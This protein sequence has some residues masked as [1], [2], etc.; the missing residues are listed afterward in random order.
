MA[1]PRD[2]L[3][4]NPHLDEWCILSAYVGSIAHGTYC[5]TKD[6]YATDDKDVQAFCVPP[7]EYYLGL[8]NFGLG[9]RET[10]EI[11]RGDWD[12]VCHETRK[13]IRLLRQGNP[14]ILM[15]L[16]MPENAYIKVSPGG[17]MLLAQRN[18]FAG[19]HVYRSF[20]GYARG[21]MHRMTHG[22]NEGYMGAKRKAL[23]DKH[24]YDTKNASHVVRLLRMAVEY[25]ST[26]QL[27]VLRDD[28]SELID[29]KRGRWSLPEVE[30]EASRLFALADAALVASRLPDGPDMVAVSRLCHDVISKT[31]RDRLCKEKE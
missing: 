8:E 27:Y 30:A 19:K 13:A 28:A 6:D 16:W 25:L 7:E 12:I 14:N 5:G 29:I 24:G 31:L 4:D 11:K 22:A 1:I 17:E 20:V 10:R 2:I 9:T 23:R 21:Q 26:G 18:L 15:M 3:A